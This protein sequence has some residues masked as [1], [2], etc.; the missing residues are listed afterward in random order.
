MKIKTYFSHM[1]KRFLF[2]SIISLCSIQK[3]VGQLKEI[4]KL[5]TSSAEQYL[6][7]AELLQADIEPQNSDWF[8]LFNTSV[9][10]M[11]IAGNAID[12]TELKSLMKKVFKPS[13]TQVSLKDLS[14][15][16]AYHYS[17]LTNQTQLK[18]YI[19]SLKSNNTVDSVKFLLYPYLPK[20][21][22]K[23]ELFPALLYCNY[24]TAEATGFG[25]IV[26]NDLLLSYK[27][28]SYKLGLLTAHE[29]FHSIVSIGFQQALKKGIDV[30]TPE[31]NLLYFLQNISEE[32]IADLIDKPLLLQNNSP[33]YNETKK[34]V[35]N[36][37]S[38]SINYIKKIDSLLKGA[39]SNVNSL[40][41]YKNFTQLANIYGQNGGHIPGR[42]MGL[43]I[44]DG[45]ILEKHIS[46]VQ[47]PISFFLS[48]NNAAK[49]QAGKYPVFSQ[50]SET[51]LLN[52]QEKYLQKEDK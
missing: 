13:M 44:K 25:G 26:I 20:Q 31:F 6:K 35:E 40:N 36:D 4:S 51:Y 37:E 12:T 14:S 46:S 22:Q 45:G 10:Q 48:Y 33:V 29:A 43:I 28:D 19:N 39:L 41:E 23:D 11:M 1:N 9:Y 34:L 5:N 17:Y 21:Y 8:A 42:F 38:L 52:L 18:S 24:G 30:N 3:A 7:M 49:L 15:T 2:I 47:N 50:E 32:G 27:I 16:E